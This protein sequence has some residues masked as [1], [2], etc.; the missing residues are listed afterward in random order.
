MPGQPNLF[1]AISL[2]QSAAA[3]ADVDRNQSSILGHRKHACEYG[4][5]VIRF[6]RIMGH[7]IAPL[8]KFSAGTTI[9]HDCKRHPA[10]LFL[11]CFEVAPIILLGF[12]GEAGEFS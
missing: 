9:L 7:I 2:V 12:F 8:F 1:G 3:L 11:D 6:S 4:P 5:S 10:E